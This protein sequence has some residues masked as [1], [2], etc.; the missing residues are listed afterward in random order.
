[1]SPRFQPGNQAALKHGLR[2]REVRQRVRQ[3]LLQAQHDLI[4]ERL[5][6]LLLLDAFLVDLLADSLADL[7]QIRAYV[8]EQGGPISSRGQL[9]KVMAMYSARMHDSVQLLDRLGVGPRARV[10]LLGTISTP[11]S[12]AQQLASRRLELEAAKQPTTHHAN[13][14]S[15]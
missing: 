15:Q 9:R 10:V 6:Q 4:R 14:G 1:M 3:E 5:P 2:S 12:L 11:N 8:N 13:G 7:A